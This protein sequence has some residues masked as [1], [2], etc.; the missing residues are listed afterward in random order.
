MFLNANLLPTL[1]AVIKDTPTVKFVIYDGKAESAKEKEAIE[2]IRSITRPSSSEG[3]AE[4][5]V[6]VLTYD[7]LLELGKKEAYEPVPPTEDDVCCIMYT[8]GSTG[9]PK[10]VILTHKNICASTT[11]VKLLLVHLFHPGDS[12]IAYLP[13]AREWW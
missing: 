13:L 9:A 4:Q 5:A 3:G 6:R 12:Y 11:A 7:E 10:G 8:S 2:H 1:S